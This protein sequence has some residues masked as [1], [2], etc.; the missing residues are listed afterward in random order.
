MTLGEIYKHIGEMLQSDPDAATRVACTR[1]DE[2]FYEIGEVTGI[3]GQNFIPLA[4]EQSANKY[5]HNGNA[6]GDIVVLD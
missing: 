2:E 6:V 1:Y 4:K 3:R 5:Q